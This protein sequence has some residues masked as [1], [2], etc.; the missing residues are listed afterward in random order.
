METRKISGDTERW[1]AEAAAIIDVVDQDSVA[2]RLVDCLAKVVPVEFAAIF[3]YRGRSRPLCLYDSFPEP[4]PKTGLRNYVET[5]YV[6]NPFYQAHMNGLAEGIYRIGGLP[7]D[8][9]VHG[10]PSD[11]EKITFTKSEEVGFVTH[12]WPKGMGEVGIA[13][14]LET[15]VTAEICLLRAA[16]RG[17][18]ADD[19]VRAI[20]L[21]YPLVKAA[22]CKFWSFQRA[23]FITLPADTGMDD[24]FQQ[25]GEGVLSSRE[26]EVMQLVLRGHTSESIG[27]NL[28]ISTTTVKTHRKRS[29]AKLGISSQSELFSLFLEK[30]G[31]ASPAN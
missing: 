29:Y 23:R 11:R 24:L 19:H 28:G 27:H 14:S 1:L 2:E 16:S 26:R 3:L 31:M 21:I 17:G 6:L 22:L 20:K 25:F 30:A 9:Y 4:G 5:T 12:G 18:F 10:A 13:I 8:A 15:G 7:P